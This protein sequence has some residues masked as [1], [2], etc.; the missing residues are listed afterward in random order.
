MGYIELMSRA[1]NVHHKMAD[2]YWINNWWKSSIFHTTFD[3]S[4]AEEHN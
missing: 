1:E 2:S 3:W 4:I